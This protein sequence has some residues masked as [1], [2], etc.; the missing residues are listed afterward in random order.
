MH[1]MGDFRSTLEGTWN[2]FTL[3]KLTCIIEGLS[4][5]IKSY[6]YSPVL[7]S[8]TVVMSYALVEDI[9]N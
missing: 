2:L 9:D 3:K 1:F 8:H 4:L 5:K 7:R 6:I